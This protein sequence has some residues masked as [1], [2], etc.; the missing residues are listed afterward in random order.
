M[1]GTVAQQAEEINAAFP[2]ME[3][4]LLAVMICGLSR[5]FGDH[6]RPLSSSFN[7]RSMATE[8]G[9]QPV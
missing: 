4:L 8:P 3:S 6:C 1:P 7:F 2:L 5:R 9:D